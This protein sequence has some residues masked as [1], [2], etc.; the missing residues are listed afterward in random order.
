M[1]T[2]SEKL[3]EIDLVAFSYILLKRRKFIVY[4]VGGI[5]FATLITLLLINRYYESSAIVM[6]SKQKN[7]F[8]AASFLKNALPLGGLGLGKTSDDLLTFTTILSSRNAY[9]RVISRFNLMKVYYEETMEK[10][11]KELTKNIEFVVNGDETALEIKVFDTDSTRAK[12]MA[13]Y[14]VEVLNDIY[15]K[16]NSTEAKSNREFIQKRYE[17]TLDDLRA[18]E[19]SL[20]G[21]QEKHHIYTTAEQMKASILAAADLKSKI[22]LREVQM[23]IVQR[24]IGGDSPEV[25]NL[26]IE[27]SEFE[28]QLSNLQRKSSESSNQSGIFIPL[29]SIPQRGLEYLR[30]FRE[31]EI[32]SKIQET[33][34]PLYEQAKIE[35]NRDTPTVVVLDVASVSDKPVKPKRI[36]LLLLV[37]LSSVLVSIFLV[38]G[39]ELVER[40]RQR[41]ENIADEKLEYITSVLHYKKFFKFD[42]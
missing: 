27:I 15:I 42:K 38:F 12:E 4:F 19:D 7:Q 21:F 8:S 39:I 11:I 30:Y 22:V 2:S 23:G 37:F 24:T 32:Q 5:F 14:F 41:P 10:T 40:M 28:K 17:R 33:L 20:R 3:Y 18:A 31:V 34:L 1:T 9:E 16:L 25:Q 35:E 13:T 36:V 6:P 29:S 26:K